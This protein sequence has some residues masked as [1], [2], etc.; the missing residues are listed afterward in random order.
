MVA[1]HRVERRVGMDSGTQA[2]PCDTYITRTYCCFDE[3]C[4]RIYNDDAECQREYDTNFE[5]YC[6]EESVTGCPC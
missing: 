6:S 2:A 4:F 5:V 1:R 3:D